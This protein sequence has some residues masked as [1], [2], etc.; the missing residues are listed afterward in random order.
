M[1]L[2]L[3]L[4]IL[5]VAGAFLMLTPAET[6]FAGL[7]HQTIGAGAGLV[8]LLA[9]Y[10][11][12][13]RPSDIARMVGSLVVWALLIAL[14]VGVYAWR[15]EASEFVG[16]MTQELMPS[17]P[18]TGAGGE[19]IVGRRLGGGFAVAARLNGARATL[20]V[21]TG[22]SM[23]VL[24]AA[25]ARRAGLATERLVYDVPVTTANGAATAA[26]VRV[27]EI[28]VGPITMRKVPALVAK[29]GVLE[30]SLLGMSFLERLKSFSVERGKLVMTAR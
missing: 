13:L 17:E 30:E 23:V 16:R 4:A 9:Y 28:A 29:P 24:T 18:A 3:P 27:D 19:A 6:R 1:R 12:N 26:A 5:A 25:D 7:D 11:V 8:A 14:A 2:A 21:D 15:Y 20:L 22:A 10:F